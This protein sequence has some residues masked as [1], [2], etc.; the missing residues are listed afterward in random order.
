VRVLDLAGIDDRTA[1]SSH[2][3]RSHVAV[4]T[5]ESAPR[6]R[7]VDAP[8]DICFIFRLSCEQ[9]AD[10]DLVTYPARGHGGWCSQL[11][12]NSTVIAAPGA[13]TSASTGITKIAS[14]ANASR[15]PAS[16]NE[17]Q[18]IDAG[19]RTALS[20]VPRA[21]SGRAGAPQRGMSG[22][23]KLRR[24]SAAVGGVRVRWRRP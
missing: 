17:R 1:N 8:A 21:A 5:D 6:Q 13:R 7:V 19:R 14:W 12:H 10:S 11:P 3:P 2:L 18:S 9:D 24:Y 16:M 23:F 15:M 20:A 4:G 22:R